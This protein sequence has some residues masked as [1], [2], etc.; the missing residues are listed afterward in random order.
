MCNCGAADRKIVERTE[1]DITFLNLGG[2][3]ELELGP[4]TAPTEA[5]TEACPE[6]VDYNSA[7]EP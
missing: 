5:S 3:F 4:A 1:N 2:S 6:T 7:Q